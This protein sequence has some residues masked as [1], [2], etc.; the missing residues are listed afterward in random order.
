ME[1]GITLDVDGWTIDDAGDLLDPENRSAGPDTRATQL[2]R[3]P[4]VTGKLDVERRFQKFTLGARLA[5]AGS[6]YYDAANLRR[7]PGYTL[8]DLR[9]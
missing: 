5:S 9:W 2:P 7:V 3:R 8:V 1:A 4:E 6:S